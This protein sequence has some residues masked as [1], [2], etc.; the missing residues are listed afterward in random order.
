MEWNGFG[1][2][3][4]GFLIYSWLPF[5][6]VLFIYFSCI[7][8]LAGELGSASI[9]HFMALVN[10]FWL[11][12]PQGVW[13]QKAGGRG[14]QRGRGEG[15]RLSFGC[16]IHL[17]VHHPCVYNTILTASAGF[18]HTSSWLFLITMA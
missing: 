6:F 3:T 7:C 11:L 5:H 8:Y 16:C 1:L 14:T 13:F 17:P 9:L 12:R 4:G 18:Q 15:R 10:C 2:E